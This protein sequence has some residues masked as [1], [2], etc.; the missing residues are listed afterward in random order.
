M[1]NY[2]G[3]SPPLLVG[4]FTAL[5]G[6]QGGGGRLSLLIWSEFKS[7]RCYKVVFFL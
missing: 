6:D 3:D 2:V 5:P 1:I 4:F 7:S